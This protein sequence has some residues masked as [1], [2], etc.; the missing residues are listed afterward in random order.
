MVVGQPILTST[1]RKSLSRRLLRKKNTLQ[2]QPPPLTPSHPTHPCAMHTHSLFFASAALL[3][4]GALFSSAYSALLIGLRIPRCAVPGGVMS[5]HAPERH[6]FEV[7]PCPYPPPSDTSAP[8][9]DVHSLRSSPG[10]GSRVL[11]TPRALCWDGKTLP[12]PTKICV[13]LL[14]DHGR[15]WD[16]PRPVSSSPP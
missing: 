12:E 5:E 15:A 14:H 11:L 10:T 3:S 4:V 2:C 8:Q 13:R 9:N 1:D 6:R 16:E 7:T